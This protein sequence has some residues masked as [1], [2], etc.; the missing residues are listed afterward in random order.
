MLLLVNTTGS[1][2][3]DIWFIESWG[4][5]VSS[6]SCFLISIFSSEFQ[7]DHHIRAVRPAVETLFIQSGDHDLAAEIDWGALLVVRS[8]A[9]HLYRNP[10]A[11][12][13]RQSAGLY[14]LASPSGGRRG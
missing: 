13:F 9:P 3:E 2:G 14:L 11:K 8:S 4:K 6:W 10:S 7:S 1:I 5:Q 12:S